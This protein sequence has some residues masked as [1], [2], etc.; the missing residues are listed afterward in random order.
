VAVKV[1]FPLL[2]VLITVLIVRLEGATDA[3]VESFLL[4]EAQN[5]RHAE[6][7]IVSFFMS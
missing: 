4:Q 3:G 5:I 2:S 7:N 6:S 1:T